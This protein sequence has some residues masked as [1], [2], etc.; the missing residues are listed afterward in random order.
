[1]FVSLNTITDKQMLYTVF[2]CVKSSHG[3]QEPRWC[4]YFSLRACTSL[5]QVNREMKSSQIKIVY[6]IQISGVYRLVYTVF[7]KKKG[8]GLND[9]QSKEQIEV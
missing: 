4:K 7:E 3:L 2:A 1:M 6:S 9:T 8:D 5:L